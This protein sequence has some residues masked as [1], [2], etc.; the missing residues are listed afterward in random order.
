MIV[1]KD[2]VDITCCTDIT[3]FPQSQYNFSLTNW[4]ELVIINSL[5]RPMI[6]RNQLQMIRKP[7]VTS[8]K[9]AAQAYI[10]TNL[11]IPYKIISIS[12][13]DK[14]INLQSINYNDNV[15]RC[16]SYVFLISNDFTKYVGNEQKIANRL[17]ELYYISFGIQAPN[18]QSIKYF[19]ISVMRFPSQ[20]PSRGSVFR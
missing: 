15:L 13:E 6:V 10:N 19:P 1:V 2:Y 3:P 17:Y 16:T 20:M 18:Q 4:V 7:Y 8:I 9:R 14:T 11:Y 5:Y 12:H